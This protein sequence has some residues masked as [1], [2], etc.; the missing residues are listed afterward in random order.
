MI[1]AAAFPF[2]KTVEDYDFEFQ[3]CVNKQEIL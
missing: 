1:K 3:L 2:V